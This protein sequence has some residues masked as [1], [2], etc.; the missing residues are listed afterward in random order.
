MVA[1][2]AGG[3]G[4]PGNAGGGNGGPVANGVAGNGAG[5]AAGGVAAGAT[6]GTTG[7]AATGA[8]LAPAAVGVAPPQQQAHIP[9]MMAPGMM[10]G[11]PYPGKTFVFDGCCVLGVPLCGES[12]C[13]RCDS[14]G[15]ET[16]KITRLVL[17]E[18]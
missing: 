13:R 12:Q 8:A 4:S 10:Y 3:A 5:G 1:G 7:V 14:M 18:S 6:G 2:G 17:W 15:V 16:E 11:Y 9:G